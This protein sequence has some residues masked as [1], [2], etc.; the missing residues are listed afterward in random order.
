MKHK[1]E[2]TLDLVVN[3]DNTTNLADLVKEHVKNCL[4]DNQTFGEVTINDI[5]LS[6]NSVSNNTERI[7]ELATKYA[8]PEIYSEGSEGYNELNSLEETEYPYFLDELA[9]LG[10]NCNY[11]TL[12]DTFTIG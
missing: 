7:K 11:N 2:M 3:S 10:F 8:H 1:I 12:T 5:D 9:H 6:V 4:L